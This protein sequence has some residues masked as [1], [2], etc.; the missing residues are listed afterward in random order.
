[1]KCRYL[2]IF[3]IFQNTTTTFSFSHFGDYTCNY[4]ELSLKTI[5]ATIDVWCLKRI[6]KIRWIFTQEVQT[7][8]K[9]CT[10]NNTVN[11]SNTIDKEAPKIQIFHSFGRHSLLLEFVIVHYIIA[12][13]DVHI[14]RIV[15]RLR[16]TGISIIP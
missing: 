11:I 13:V 12:M 2:N 9:L 15:Y 8:A 5:I 7:S 1:M 6:F 14:K 10:Y 16:D 4:A 3:L